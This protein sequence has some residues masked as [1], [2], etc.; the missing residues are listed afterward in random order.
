M[1]S[2]P[3]THITLQLVPSST[4]IH[5]YSAWY[6]FLVNFFSRE[7]EQNKRRDEKCILIYEINSFIMSYDM[8]WFLHNLWHYIYRVKWNLKRLDA[9][10]YG[11]FW[12]NIEMKWKEKLELLYSIAN[13]GPP[14]KACHAMIFGGAPKFNSEFNPKIQY[15][16]KKWLIFHQQSTQHAPHII[17][18]LKLIHQCTKPF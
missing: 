4:F 11:I 9:E 13:I 8:T 6:F 1:R 10:N 17:Q 18:Y 2:N 3:Q 16:P 15:F 14:F 5:I 7:S 12:I